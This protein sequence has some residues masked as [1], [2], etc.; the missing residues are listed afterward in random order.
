MDANRSLATRTSEACEMMK[1]HGKENGLTKHARKFRRA[2]LVMLGAFALS[3]S[4]TSLAA[5]NDAAAQDVWENLAQAA[6][7]STNDA[8]LAGSRGMGGL[9]SA[10]GVL[11]VILWDEKNTCCG[12]PNAAPAPQPQGG[13]HTVSFRVVIQK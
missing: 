7:T 4:G 13:T 8:A 9:A 5:E 11:A 3:L 10:P 2:A 12:K 1:L 6:T